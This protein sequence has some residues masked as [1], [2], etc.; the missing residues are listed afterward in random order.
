MSGVMADRESIFATNWGRTK[1]SFL[2]AVDDP[3][4]LVTRGL[5]LSRVGGVRLAWLFKSMDLE[6]KDCYA[7]ARESLVKGKAQYS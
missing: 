1:M 7:F 5:G 2:K 6:R 3:T 4:S